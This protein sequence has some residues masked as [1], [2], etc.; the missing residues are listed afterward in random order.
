AHRTNALV[1]FCSLHTF[2]ISKEARHPWRDVALEYR[3]VRLFGCRQLTAGETG[4]DLAQDV[5]TILRLGDA[6][7]ARDVEAAQIL[8]QARQ[9]P[10][11]QEASDIIRRVR[12]EL[13]ATD[14]NEEIEEF[15]LHVGRACAFGS[16]GQF[17]MRGSE[18]RFIALQL[19]DLL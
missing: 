17:T 2:E 15:A 8:T 16:F 5:G 7:G 12:Q 11:V 1:E 3:A 6:F 4:H 14:A 13:A 9:R 19:S 18:P 10:F